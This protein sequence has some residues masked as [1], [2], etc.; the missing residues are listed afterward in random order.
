[1]DAP[2]V[3]SQWR[4]GRVPWSIWG[5]YSTCV[6][7]TETESSRPKT[8]DSSASN[9]SERR[10]YLGNSHNPRV[11]VVLF[12][13]VHKRVCAV[14]RVWFWWKSCTPLVG[15]VSSKHKLEVG[16][17]T[18]RVYSQWVMTLF[19]S[20]HTLHT[21]LLDKEDQ[22]STNWFDWKWHH[23]HIEWG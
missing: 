21:S 1:M 10:R 16:V 13:V 14:Y 19:D 6:T 20:V 23:C 8:F 2:L 18:R 3:W 9:T 4:R 12:Y 17:G 11:Y 15:G 7:G 22:A 5:W